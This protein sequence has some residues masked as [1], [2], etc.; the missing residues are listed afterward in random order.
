MPWSQGS[1]VECDWGDLWLGG[2]GAVE[3]G[4]GA[5]DPSLPSPQLKVPGAPTRPQA[6]PRWQP[7]AKAA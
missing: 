5:S 6:S 4:G 3:V 1:G 2:R 7:S